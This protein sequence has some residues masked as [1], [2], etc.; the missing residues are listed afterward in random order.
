MGFRGDVCEGCL[1]GTCLGNASGLSRRCVKDPLDFIGLLQS[2]NNCIGS[3]SP[4]P[5]YGGPDENLNSAGSV[6]M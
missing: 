4:V 1:G 3:V 2:Q 6:F 5:Q